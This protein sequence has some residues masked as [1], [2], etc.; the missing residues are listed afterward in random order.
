MSL[1]SA[2]SR[3]AVARRAEKGVTFPVPLRIERRDR[4]F[5]KERQVGLLRAGRSMSMDHP[6]MS[7][8]SDELR[9]L[10]LSKKGLR[11]GVGDGDGVGD[12]GVG[13]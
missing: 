13:C 12:V 2:E 9:A 5:M 8:T 3:P 1:F 10:M 11:A 4:A 7:M 6:K